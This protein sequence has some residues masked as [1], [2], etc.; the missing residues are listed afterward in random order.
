MPVA[1][2]VAEL[3]CWLR[4]V[5]RAGHLDYTSALYVSLLP[6]DM[7]PPVHAYLSRTFDKMSDRSSL[8]ALIYPIM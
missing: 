2:Q 4:L 6:L 7:T 1:V 5:P 8:I 3:A